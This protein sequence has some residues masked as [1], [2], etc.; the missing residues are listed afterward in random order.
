MMVITLIVKKN[1][2]SIWKP[3][4]PIYTELYL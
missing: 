1:T 3:R 4:R 2:V